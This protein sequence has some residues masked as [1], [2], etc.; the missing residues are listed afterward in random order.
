M[1]V[2]MFGA[3]AVLTLSG[4]CFAGLYLWLNLFSTLP[5][6]VERSKN[7]LRI[8]RVSV[9]L[10]LVFAFLNSIITE[11]DSIEAIGASATLFTIIAISY[12]VVALACG[13]AMIYSVTSRYAYRR[14]LGGV[15]GKLFIVSALGG[16]VGLVLAWLLG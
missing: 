3:T 9:I 15:V 13:V 16:A 11:M 14:G 8:S 10:S 1:S 2:I 5:D 6:L 7:A 12:F 4:V